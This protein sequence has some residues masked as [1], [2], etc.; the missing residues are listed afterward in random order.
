MR[1]PIEIEIESDMLLSVTVKAQ[2]I[3]ERPVPHCMNHDSPQFSDSGDPA[4][5]VECQVFVGDCNI[6]EWLSVCQQEEIEEAIL[7]YVEENPDRS[8]PY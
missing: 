5:I 3:P 6:T 4:E 8:D 7:K 2:V 1:N